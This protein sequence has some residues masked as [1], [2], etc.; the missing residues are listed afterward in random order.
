MEK[1]QTTNLKNL[2]WTFQDEQMWRISSYVIY[3]KKEQSLL[4][5]R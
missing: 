1:I 3:Y 2:G 5:E 4:K